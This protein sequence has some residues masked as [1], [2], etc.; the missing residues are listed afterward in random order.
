MAIGQN[1]GTANGGSIQMRPYKDA[2]SYMPLKSVRTETPSAF[3]ILASE[4]TEMVS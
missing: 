1:F 3:A 2:Y 4:S